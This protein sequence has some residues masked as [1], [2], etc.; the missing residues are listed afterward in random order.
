V[1]SFANRKQAN[2]VGADCVWGSASLACL[3]QNPVAVTPDR[4]QLGVTWTRPVTSG[5]DMHE[6]F[7]A[8][9]GDASSAASTATI[10]A[11]GSL[12]FPGT[13]A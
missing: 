13:R 3:F 11:G 1:L 10:P 7:T 9:D 12:G 8:K 5:D 2:R 6:D 4:D